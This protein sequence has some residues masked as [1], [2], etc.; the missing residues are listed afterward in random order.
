M[1]QQIGYVG[2]GVD[3]MTLL[4]LKTGMSGLVETVSADGVLAQRLL[5]MG[6]YPGAC[7]AFV[8]KAPLGDP[9]EFV[10]EGYSLGLRR[11][12]AGC[13]KVKLCKKG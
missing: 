2:E 3:D 12:E 4:D 1:M 11:K 7:V 8:R 5:D 6:F 10:V 9:I 13:V